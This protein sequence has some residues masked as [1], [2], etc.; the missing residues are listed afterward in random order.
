LG[1]SLLIRTEKLL[2]IFTNAKMKNVKLVISGRIGM[3]VGYMK[4]TH[5]EKEAQP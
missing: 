1:A 4:D 5:V 2:A 3:K